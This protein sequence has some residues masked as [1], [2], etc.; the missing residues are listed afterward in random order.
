MRRFYRAIG[1]AALMALVLTACGGGSATVETITAEAGKA[2]LDSGSVVLVDVRRVDEYESAHI[3]GAILVPNESIG[4]TR[5]EALPDLEASIVV[6]CRTG[7]RSKEAAGKLV[8]L[9]YTDVKDMG[10]I[11]DWPYDTVTGSEPGEYVRGALLGQFSVTDLEGNSVDESLLAKADL[12]LVN[13]WATYCGPC[14]REMPDLGEVAA[15]YADKG[16]QVVGIVTDVLTSDG[17]I[18]ESQVEL[19]RDVVAETKADYL[20]LLP[21]DG[22]YSLLSQI[23]AVPTTFFV[24]SEGRQVGSAYVQSLTKAQFETIIDET[25]AEVTK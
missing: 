25:L 14:L 17:A 1:F 6:Y 9:G 11:S 7:V 19:A 10:G 2:L 3:P 5:P 16:V 21:G 18:S 8:A 24:D 20:H 4:D 22:L 12:T 23:Y 15:A 13:V